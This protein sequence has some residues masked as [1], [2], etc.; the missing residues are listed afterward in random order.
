M[1]A[2]TA[3]GATAAAVRS[4]RGI[5]TALAA[6]PTALGGFL[7]DYRRRDP[8]GLRT[9]VRRRGRR[10]WTVSRAAVLRVRRPR[11]IPTAGARLA[12]A[13]PSAAASIRSITARTPICIGCLRWSIRRP[14]S[15]AIARCNATCSR[16]GSITARLP[17]PGRSRAGGTPP[18][19]ARGAAGGTVRYG[20]S[21][22]LPAKLLHAPL[23]LCE[24]NPLHRGRG[25]TAEEVNVLR[26]ARKVGEE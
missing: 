14:P 26:T 16:A 17:R 22:R 15:A 23:L 5:T 4:A 20:R 3:M 24:R 19:A 18:P 25:A 8:D 12:K 9:T 1:A 13:L 7:A 10:V 6:R 21:R 11:R 2:A